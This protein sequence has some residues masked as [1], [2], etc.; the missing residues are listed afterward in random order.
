M[1]PETTEN[2]PTPISN[3]IVCDFLDIPLLKS[4]TLTP[5][6]LVKITAGIN[7]VCTDFAQLLTTTKTSFDL[8]DV[9]A[10]IGATLEEAAAK[11]PTQHQPVWD[12]I[13]ALD[14]ETDPAK[15]LWAGRLARWLLT[16]ETVDGD[17]MD[18]LQT[19]M[20]RARDANPTETI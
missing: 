9:L 16:V 11:K 14:E 12:M 13:V 1:I 2:S 20:K 10:D 8:I 19:L 15:L 6:I 17:D 4:T 3:G 7:K 5:E 18:T